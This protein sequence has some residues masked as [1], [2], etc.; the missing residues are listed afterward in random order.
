MKVLIILGHPRKSS[1]CSALAVA[2]GKGA[3]QAGMEVRHLNVA[4]LVFDPDVHTHSPREQ[5]QEPDVQRAQ[6]LLQWAD[7]WV[8]VFPNWWG[9]MPARLKGFL[10]RVLVPGFAFHEREGGGYEGLLH[11]K[12]AHLLLTMDT[13]PWVYRLILKQPGVQALKAATL[14]FCGVSPVRVSLFGVVKGAS[15]E[16]CQKW[17]QEAEYEGAK[18]CDGVP[19]GSEK[20]RAKA[21]TWLQAIRLQFYPMA[22]VAYTVGALAA[23]LQTGQLLAAPYWGGYAFLFFLEVATVFLNDHFDFETDRRN[24]HYSPFSG[25]SRVLVEQRLSFGEL[26]AGIT[27]VLILCLVSAGVVL[28]LSPAPVVALIPLL[29]IAAAITL[30]YTA[31]PLKLAYNVSAELDVCLTHS[32]LLILCGWMFQ[33][34]DWNH[35]LPWLMSVPLFLAGLP[36]ITLAAIPDRESDATVGKKTFAVRLGSPRAMQ[37]AA[38]FTVTAAFV[39]LMW[40]ALGIGDGLFASAGYWIV[41]H[42]LLLLWLLRCHLQKGKTQGRINALMIA[43]LTYIL[44]FGLVPLWHLWHRI[45]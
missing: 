29:A 7:H 24:R 44:P 3:H 2:Y 43:S 34:Q 23:A 8:F 28:A 36:S 19:S 6:E 12:S 13:P 15:P 4:D 21:L 25:G 17:L 33:G 30:G 35:A 41:P 27:V 1:F 10:D 40:Q 5:H 9:S 14:K 26:R 11:E 38:L 39:A 18:L 16:Q 20:W 31:P 37:L 42:A 22:W 45:R 32:L